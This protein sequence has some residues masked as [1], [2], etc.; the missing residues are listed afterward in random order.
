M[1]VKKMIAILESEYNELVRKA[2]AY[3]K[4]NA[5]SSKGGKNA[6][7]NLTPEERSIRA[8][9]AVQARIKKYGQK[10]NG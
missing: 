2:E 8:K 5:G 9:K 6:W 10:A 3:D 1:A 7:A 4:M